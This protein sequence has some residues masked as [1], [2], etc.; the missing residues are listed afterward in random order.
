MWRCNRKE[1]KLQFCIIVIWRSAAS[2]FD[3]VIRGH[4]FQHRKILSPWKPRSFG[5]LVVL[6]H[7]TTHFGLG[8]SYSV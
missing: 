3:F 5:F 2:E 1:H 6:F 4:V 7:L 8:T